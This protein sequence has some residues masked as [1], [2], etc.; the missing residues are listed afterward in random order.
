MS[1]VMAAL[2]GFV[3]DTVFVEPRIAEILRPSYLAALEPYDLCRH[4]NENSGK[5]GIDLIGDFGQ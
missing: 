5:G 1:G 2:V 3:L 4:I